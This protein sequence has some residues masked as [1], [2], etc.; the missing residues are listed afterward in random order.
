MRTAA[1]IDVK[2]TAWLSVGDSLH[3]GM[4]PEAPF[5]ISQCCQAGQ[6]M[7]CMSGRS[8]TAGCCACNSHHHAHCRDMRAL[9]L[10]L[11]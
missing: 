11:V 9:L 3:V 6:L 2:G 4:R 7:Q 8:A 10:P 1:A 5:S